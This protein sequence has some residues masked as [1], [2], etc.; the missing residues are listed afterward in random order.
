MKIVKCP[1]CDFN[2]R[3]KEMF[4]PDCGKKTLHFERNPL[5]IFSLDFLKQSAI[6]SFY[7]FLI[8]LILISTLTFATVLTSG[9]NLEYALNLLIHLV[10]VWLLL[11]SI[12]SLVLCLISFY[13]PKN[14]ELLGLRLR[15]KTIDKRLNDLDA[16]QMEIDDILRDIKTGETENLKDVQAKLLTAKNTLDIQRIK[17]K[18]QQEKIKLVRL[19][20]DVSP[21]IFEFQ[22]LNDEELDTGLLTI[23]TTKNGVKE[24]RQNVITESNED[25]PETKKFIEQLTET[26]DSYSRLR[27]AIIRKQAT[28]A[29]D[30]ISPIDSYLQA[31]NS[32]EVAHA[33]ETFNANVELSVSQESFNELENEYQRENTTQQ[34]TE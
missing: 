5:D 3:E 7:V 28:N 27:E 11:S 17:Y 32:D 23:E 6:L 2:I 29:V 22:N 18:L 9:Q 4:C 14:N 24:L 20:N 26:E 10:P 30:E 8:F 19:Q 13:I 25:L 15:S 31:E 16:R 33:I 1:N 21:L 34:I 12:V